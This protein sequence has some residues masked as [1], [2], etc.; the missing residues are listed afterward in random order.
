MFTD[1]ISEEKIHFSDKNKLY[2]TPNEDENIIIWELS[3][4][5]NIYGRSS[6]VMSKYKN[7]FSKSLK[8]YS[9]S[10]NNKWS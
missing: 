2:Y 9:G 7:T 10:R 6:E 3:C 8:K 1:E 5:A 4:I